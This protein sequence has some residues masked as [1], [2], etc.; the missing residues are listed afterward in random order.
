MTL[1]KDLALDL[2]AAQR[3]NLHGL[4]QEYL[5]DDVVVEHFFAHHG[6]PLDP[7]ELLGGLHSF[8]SH[9]DL[10]QSL[11]DYLAARRDATPPDPRFDPDFLPFPAWNPASA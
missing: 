1:R 6:V 11:E 4:M 10:I 2:T 9:R 5:T 7:A 8:T 3:T